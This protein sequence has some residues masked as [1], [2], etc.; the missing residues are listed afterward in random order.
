M[1]KHTPTIRRQI[2]DEL[3]E[4]VWSFNKVGAWRVKI[5]SFSFIFQL[6]QMLLLFLHHTP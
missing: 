1:V 2:A 4:C 3:F 6:L 5:F